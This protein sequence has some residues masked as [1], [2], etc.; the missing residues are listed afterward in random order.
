MR[1]PAV[2][3]WGLH[4][5]TFDVFFPACLLFMRWARI[6]LLFSCNGNPSGPA[7]RIQATVALADGA[8]WLPGA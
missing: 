4:R 6:G 2:S 7:T 3:G 5:L 8:W 1:V